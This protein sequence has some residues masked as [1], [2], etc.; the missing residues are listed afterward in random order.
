MPREV[1]LISDEPLSKDVA[2]GIAPRLVPG[3]QVLEFPA[4]PLLYLVD[5]ERE[6]LL[7][8]GPSRPLEDFA[9]AGGTINEAGVPGQYWTDLL[10][11]YSALHSGLRA[12][13]RL[14]SAIG[15]RVQGK[16]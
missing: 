10:V 9:A 16:R 4:V 14:A 5:A 3:G 1:A 7:T 2:L 15:G 8:I 11:P 6:P 12:A 13:E